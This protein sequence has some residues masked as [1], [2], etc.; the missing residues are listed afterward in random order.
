MMPR[1]SDLLHLQLLQE[2]GDLCKLKEEPPLYFR[3]EKRLDSDSIQHCLRLTHPS[4]RQA[5]SLK[6]IA[7]L[8]LQGHV[9][10][11]RSSTII[12]TTT[13]SATKLPFTAQARGASFS[14]AGSALSELQCSREYKT[15]P[16]ETDT[17]R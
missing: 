10:K 13:V 4:Q 6:G 3:L 14:Y 11:G 1:Q 5:A 15:Y 12:T 16:A 2:N 8:R 7:I 17:H 9:K